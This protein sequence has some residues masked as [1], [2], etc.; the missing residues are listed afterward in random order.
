MGYPNCEGKQ[1]YAAITSPADFLKYQ[2][3]YGH[4]RE[5]IIP[6]R[7]ILTYLPDPIDHLLSLE[8]GRRYHSVSYGLSLLG[9]GTKGINLTGIGATMASM[10][11]EELIASGTKRFINVGLAGSLQG[12]LQ[13]GDIVVCNSA[14]RDEGVS[15][16]Y[17]EAA[18]FVNTSESITEQ[19]KQSLTLAK[20]DFSEGIIWT[21]A[22]P[23]RE[24][25]RELELYQ[26]E[27]VLAVDLETAALAAV[28]RY[29]GVEFAS[30]FVV[31]DLLADGLWVPKFHEE[32]VSQRLN[33]L[34]RVALS[35][36]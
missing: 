25:T 12:N 11:M 17:L 26:K 35:I 19:L 13:T 28:A 18:K 20:K 24:T 21:I 5:S 27:G 14:I 31:S 3:E 32:I 29:R 6:E 16:H 4:P 22:T 9:D 36:L 30:V 8:D 33:S 34:H 15:H 2:E 1:D 10:A 23:Y 7:V